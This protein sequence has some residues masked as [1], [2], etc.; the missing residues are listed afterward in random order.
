MSSSRVR[1]A[2]KARAMVE[3]RRMALRR[4]MTSS[5]YVVGQLRAQRRFRSEVWVGREVAYLQLVDEHGD[6]V[7]LI[8]RI[9]RVSHGERV[10]RRDALLERSNNNTKVLGRWRSVSARGSLIACVRGDVIRNRL[11]QLIPLLPRCAQSTLWTVDGPTAVVVPS[12]D[13]GC[14]WSSEKQIA[15]VPPSSVVGER[16]GGSS[17]DVAAFRR[18]YGDEVGSRCR[19]MDACW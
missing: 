11:L 2:P 13:A 6:G 9:R 8:V 17:R 7:E 19:W 12:Q 4:R 3:R 14:V 15:M 18:V 16:W 10:G 5:C 1:S